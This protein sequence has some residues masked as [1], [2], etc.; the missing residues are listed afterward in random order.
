[1]YNPNPQNVY[2]V[3]VYD[4]LGFQRDF[5]SS[6][7]HGHLPP[8]YRSTQLPPP[9]PYHPYANS[10]PPVHHPA[11]VVQGTK[12]SLCSPRRK[13]NVL[14]AFAICVLIVA[15]I[16]AAVLAW[17]FVTSKC[18]MKCWSSSQCVSASQWCDGTVQCPNGEDEAYCV[19]L[20]GPEFLLQAY[21]SVKGRWLNVCSDKWNDNF[22]KAACQ[23]LGYSASTYYTSG[24]TWLGYTLDFY[25]VL[26]YSRPNGK[27]QTTLSV[28][29]SCST[30]TGVSLRCINCGLNGSSTSSRIV[31]GNIASTSKWPWQVGLY[32]NLRFTCGGSIITPNWIVTAA[33]CVEGTNAYAS[34]WQV[35]YGSL[36]KGGG[37]SSFVEKV[38]AHQN[39]DTKTKNNDIAL[40]KLKSTITFSSAARPV[41]L[42]NHGMNWVADKQCWI[43][44]WGATYEGGSSTSYLRDA[45][46]KLIDSTTCNK[47]SVYNDAIT[48]TMICAGY[49]SG[50]ID[51]CQ[52]DSGG[53][54]VTQT[55]NLWWLVGDTSWGN[56]CANVNKPG[57]YG[58]VTVF[59]EWIYL[60][61]QTYR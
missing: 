18:E 55:N 41:C 11:P 22:G 32:S 33:H 27:L 49:L 51:T 16:I 57:V 37:F 5:P 60:Q 34:V 46:V 59:L 31:G 13:N 48:S 10:Q 23:E 44:G 50:G 7:I 21:S 19:R 17:Y 29:D 14:I 4:N 45:S 2:S 40:M 58:N 1:M 25:A 35:Y 3:P 43:S 36:Q 28:S 39:Y 42:P 38:I 56:G 6:N 15:A 53:P 52:G 8:P 20:Y 9:P 61:M 47:P 12:A 24:T 30:F 26:N 54:L